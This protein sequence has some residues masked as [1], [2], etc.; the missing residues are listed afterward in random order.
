MNIMPINSNFY[1]V[2]EKDNNFIYKVSFDKENSTP[3]TKYI[4]E[5]EDGRRAMSTH[6]H[7]I[8]RRKKHI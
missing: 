2:M 5:V 1:M 7:D 4:W 8:N 6:F 3:L